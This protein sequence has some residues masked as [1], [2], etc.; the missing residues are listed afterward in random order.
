MVLLEESQAV[1]A[2]AADT[3]DF[4]SGL[5]QF[6]EMVAEEAGLFGAAAGEGGRVEEYDDVFSANVVS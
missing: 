4:D 6:G 5:L 1:G 2:V 3:H